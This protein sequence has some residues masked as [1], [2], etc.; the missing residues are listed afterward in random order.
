MFK[1]LKLAVMA[2]IVA[3]VAAFLNRDK[4]KKP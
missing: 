1:L 2:V 3:T 4:R